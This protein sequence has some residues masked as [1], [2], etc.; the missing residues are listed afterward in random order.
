MGNDD[1][2]SIA[3]E[4]A[5]MFEHFCLRSRIATSHAN[6]S[7][8]YNRQPLVARDIGEQ[9]KAGD[10]RIIGVMIES[11]LVAGAQKLVE[12]KPLVYGQ[13]VTD[14]CLAWPE[15]ETTIAVL[16]DAVAA[17]RARSVATQA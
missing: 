8:D 15:T 14:A 6:S 4:F 3:G 1:G 13:S 12:G 11:N 9:I 10:R 7:K 17:R 2:D 5:K 16:A